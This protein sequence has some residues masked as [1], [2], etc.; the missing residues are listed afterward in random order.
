MLSKTTHNKNGDAVTYR[1]RSMHYEG[2]THYHIERSINGGK[3]KLLFGGLGY[4]E[5]IDYIKY[6]EMIESKYQS[7]RATGLII[8]LFLAVVGIIF[9]LTY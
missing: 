5:A 2:E 8:I 9:Y 6:P 4:N 1:V 7:L 3:F